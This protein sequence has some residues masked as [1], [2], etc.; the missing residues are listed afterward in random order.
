MRLGDGNTPFT[1]GWRPDARAPLFNVA[2]YGYA[3]TDAWRLFGVMLRA[4]S[5]C[6][7][8]ILYLHVSYF[9]GG[10]THQPTQYDCAVSTALPHMVT[11]LLNLLLTSRSTYSETMRTS[12]CVCL[13][14][15]GVRPIGH[16]PCLRPVNLHH[17][18]Q[19]H[20]ITRTRLL[21]L[22]LGWPATFPQYF[23]ET[24]NTSPSE[25]KG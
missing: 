6:S 4:L 17:P 11:L 24:Y 1:L 23:R 18:H 12:R 15:Q 16:G 14:L 22:S 20:N 13:A 2:I 19:P 9:A 3:K 25:V 5:L 10:S 7:A 8:L 21:F